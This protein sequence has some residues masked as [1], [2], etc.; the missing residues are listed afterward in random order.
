VTKRGA[1]YPRKPNDFYA[2]PPEATQALLDHVSFQHRVCDPAC[3]DGAILN[4]LIANGYHAVGD[5]IT[6]Q[7]NFLTD[8]FRWFNCNIV[9]NPPFGI[10]GRDALLFIRR[11]LQV[12][13]LRIAM[14]LPVDYDSGKTRRA[15]FADCP[16]FAIKLTLLN[17]IR[18]F[19]G[20]SGSLNHAWFIWDKKHSGGP[21]LRYAEQKYPSKLF[22]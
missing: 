7:Y 13:N 18:W 15:V 2:T 10:G 11:A 8:R 1:D 21:R 6:N 16:H 9:T 14:L 5:D 22:S 4:V 12:C 17:R 19:N 20:V 3:G